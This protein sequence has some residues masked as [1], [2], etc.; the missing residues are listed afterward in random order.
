MGSATIR[1]KGSIPSLM[2][3]FSAHPCEIAISHLC[4]TSNASIEYVSDAFGCDNLDQF[5]LI[6][7]HF[8]FP[9]LQYLHAQIDSDPKAVFNIS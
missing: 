5:S 1:S 4:F 9:I 8:S 7:V 6:I 3:V 2:T